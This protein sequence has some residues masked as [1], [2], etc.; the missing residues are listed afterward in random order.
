MYF[1]YNYLLWKFS[2]FSHQHQVVC[3]IKVLYFSRSLFWV[4]WIMNIFFTCKAS[5][6]FPPACDTSKVW[7]LDPCY[8]ACRPCQCTFLRSCW[9][10]RLT[11][12][13]ISKTSRIK[14]L[15][16]KRK[17]EKKL[18]LI[19]VNVSFFNLS[20]VQIWYGEPSF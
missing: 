12:H 18:L 4:Y 19:Y 20:W 9:T 3:L 7:H 10:L 16:R 6:G 14:F 11:N 17:E 8:Q 13:F 2:K 5:I 1:Y 15:G